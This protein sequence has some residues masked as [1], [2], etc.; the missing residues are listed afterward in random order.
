MTGAS[1]CYSSASLALQLLLTLPHPPHHAACVNLHQNYLRLCFRIK[2]TLKHEAPHFYAAPN[3]RS[4][5]H[6]LG[7][8]A[9]SWLVSARTTILYVVSEYLKRRS[10]ARLLSTFLCCLAIVIRPVARLGGSYAF[11]VLPF[12]A[13][14]F[15][16]QESLAQQLE[17]TALNIA[18]ALCG[19]GFSTFGKYLASL[20]GEDSVRARVICAVFLVVISFLGE[21]SYSLQWGVVIDGRRGLELYLRFCD[22]S[23]VFHPSC[24]CSALSLATLCT[25]RGFLGSSPVHDMGTKATLRDPMSYGE[26][27][28]CRSTL[29]NRDSIGVSSQTFI[30]RE[31]PPAQPCS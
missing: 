16:V 4:H 29:S 18:G 26:T 12:Q 7:K 11:L 15:G 27:D 10:L 21:F 2:V 1:G 20:T 3:A 5:C 28:T 9:M 31:T 25:L 23:F 19:I 8:F 6:S 22:V 24:R 14:V 17:L 13:L 30:V